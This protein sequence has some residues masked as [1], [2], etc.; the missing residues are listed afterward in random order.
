MTMNK[1]LVMAHAGCNNTPINTVDS[2]LKGY[3]WGADINEIDVRATR[4]GV[5]ILWHD[6]TLDTRSSGPV[7]VKRLTYKEILLLESQDDIK[8]SHRD[9]KI[10]SLEE[11]LMAVYNRNIQLN[12]DLKDDECIIPASILVKKLDLTGWVVFSG[13]EQVRAFY[14]KKMYPEFQVLLN[15]DEE[16]FDRE[17]L[18]YTEK[19]RTICDIA[20]SAGCCGI[21]I[22]HDFC[23]QE[24]VNYAN[25]RFLPVVVWTVSPED[26]FEAYINM[27]VAFINT[28]YVK[29][30]VDIYGKG[31]S[32]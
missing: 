21:N 3:G 9:G 24:F 31:L 15:A 13:C 7:F 30:L 5:P 8:F 1:T 26:G 16:L 28:L 23:S 11:M 29:E 14:L 6:E 2:V 19:I 27:G 32:V 10:T 17:D 18:T 22:R 25:C 4:D 12:L 20:V